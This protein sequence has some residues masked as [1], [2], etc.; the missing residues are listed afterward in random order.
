MEKRRLRGT[1]N[2]LRTGMDVRG[3]TAL[4][5]VSHSPDFLTGITS[6][7]LPHH[8]PSPRK[9][10]NAGSKQRGHNV[11]SAMICR[12][13]NEPRFLSEQGLVGRLRQ[14]Q[15]GAEA[16]WKTSFMYLAVPRASKQLAQQCPGWNHYRMLYLKAIHGFKRQ[17]DDCLERVCRL[18]LRL[19]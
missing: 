12:R 15:E 18:R 1:Q 6:G 8:S 13:G 9:L 16:A 7:S 2:A 14:P 10:L 3:R 17:V 5:Y 19:E 4:L 11:N